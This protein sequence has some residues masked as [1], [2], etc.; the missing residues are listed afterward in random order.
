MSEEVL[1]FVHRK[2]KFKKIGYQFEL[3]LIFFTLGNQSLFIT[4]GGG[5]G[6]FCKNHIECGNRETY[7][8]TCTCKE[9]S[10]V[11]RMALSGLNL[12]ENN[13]VRHDREPK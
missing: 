3:V 10:S 13:T 12:M 8:K 6:K 7:C 5:V 11:S 1:R 9:A 2:K 4:W